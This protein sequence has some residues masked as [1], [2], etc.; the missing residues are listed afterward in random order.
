M[1]VDVEAEAPPGDGAGRRFDG[2]VT[3]GCEYS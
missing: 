2:H 1:H 3:A